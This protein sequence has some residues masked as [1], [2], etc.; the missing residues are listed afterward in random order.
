[1]A[2][3]SPGAPSLVMVYG[4]GRPRLTRSRR[5][6]SQA[7]KLSFL[8]RVNDNNTL[9]PSVVIA[10]AHNTASFYMPW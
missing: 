2:R 5:K 3:K 6:E 8:A 9:S 4:T 1:M 10:Q 7:S